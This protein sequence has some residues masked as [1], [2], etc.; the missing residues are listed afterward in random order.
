MSKCLWFRLI[1]FSNGIIVQRHQTYE[2]LIFLKRRKISVLPASVQFLFAQP[3]RVQYCKQQYST[4]MMYPPW[5]KRNDVNK[6]LENF[7]ENKSQK[8]NRIDLKMNLDDRNQGCLLHTGTCRL[9]WLF[10]GLQQIPC[11]I[12]EMLQLELTTAISLPFYFF[13]QFIN[14]HYISPPCTAASH[15]FV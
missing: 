4:L 13:F 3:Y 11:T 1:I 10:Y 12:D 8:L 9:L 14:S 6:I 15:P 7:T 2:K 5:S